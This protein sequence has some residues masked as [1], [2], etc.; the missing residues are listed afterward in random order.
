LQSFNNRRQ[1]FFWWK[2]ITSKVPGAIFFL[3]SDPDTMQISVAS[4]VFRGN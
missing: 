3:N 2:E 1:K 4:I